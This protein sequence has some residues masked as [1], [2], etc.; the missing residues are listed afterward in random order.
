MSEQI[1]IKGQLTKGPLSDPDSCFTAISVEDTARVMEALRGAGGQF[2]VS[3]DPNRREGEVRCDVI[4]FWKQ[5]DIVG[6]K[7]L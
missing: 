2:D 3:V 6:Y 4:W 5:A 7:G 1:V